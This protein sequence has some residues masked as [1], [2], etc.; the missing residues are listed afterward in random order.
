MPAP[1]YNATD[2]DALAKSESIDGWRGVLEREPIPPDRR[3]HLTES[4][5][6]RRERRQVTA[7]GC[8]AR[9]PPRDPPC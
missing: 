2:G 4:G 8:G 7:R 6:A 5:T 1:N 3:Q 9:A